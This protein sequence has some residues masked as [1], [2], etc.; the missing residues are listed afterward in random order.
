MKWIDSYKSKLCTAEKAAYAIQSNQRVYVHPGCATPYVL[1]NA[2]CNIDKHLE[3]VE[4]IHL[5]TLGISPYSSPEMA[6]R[7]R[8]NA[9]FIGKNVRKAIN[10]GRADFTPVFL[11]EIPYLL[12][13][14][15]YLSMYH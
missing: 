6:G 14:I 7:F 12:K 2:M 10:E 8:H 9:L 15:F 4:V 3:N 11:F 5:L 1:L 13:G